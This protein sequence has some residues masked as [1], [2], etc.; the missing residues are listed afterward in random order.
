MSF[1]VTVTAVDIFGQVALGYAG[2]VTFSTTDTDHMRQL[3]YAHGMEYY[4]SANH[5]LLKDFTTYGQE[6]TALLLEAS[7]AQAKGLDRPIVYLNSRLTSKEDKARRIA[8]HDRVRDGLICVF[9]CWRRAGP[10][11]S[12]ATPNAGCWNCRGN[13]ANA[14]ICITISSIRCLDKTN[15]KTA[16]SKSADGIFSKSELVHLSSHGRVPTLGS[17][18]AMGG[19]EC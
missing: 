11:R 18:L 19:Q 6:R 14:R 12:I 7:L 17:S 9:K 13:R 5:V 15:T 1:D 3:F 8:E 10:S 4:S 2:T 16:L